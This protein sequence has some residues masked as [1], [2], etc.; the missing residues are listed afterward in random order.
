MRGCIRVCTSRA[1]ALPATAGAI[2]IQSRPV[3]TVS[4]AMSYGELTTSPP[5]PGSV[6]TSMISDG[7]KDCEIEP[8]ADAARLVHELKAKDLPELHGLPSGSWCSRRRPM[9]PATALK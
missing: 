1:A 4:W 3:R 6:L 9:R 2:R 5:P 8:G 7:K